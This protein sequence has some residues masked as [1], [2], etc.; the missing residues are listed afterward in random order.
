MQKERRDFI[1]KSAVAA[2]TLAVGS[3]VANAGAFGD[4]NDIPN[5][6]KARYS[7]KSEI[8]YQKTDNWNKFY[9]AATYNRI[10]V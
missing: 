8:M 2:G 4:N 1:K 7:S 10:E 9:K 6:D 3:T 5:G